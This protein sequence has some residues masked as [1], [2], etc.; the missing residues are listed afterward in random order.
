MRGDIMDI[1]EVLGQFHQLDKSDQQ[2]LRELIL[3]ETQPDIF[4]FDAWFVQTQTIRK[5]YED[6]L[7]SVDVVSLLRDIRDGEDE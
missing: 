1:Y 7:S 5:E 6:Q 4:D 3:L 2:R